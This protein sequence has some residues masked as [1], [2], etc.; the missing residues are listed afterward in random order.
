MHTCMH[1]HMQIKYDFLLNI[2]FNKVHISNKIIYIVHNFRCIYTYML[3]YSQS[4]SSFFAVST[5]DPSAARGWFWVGRS[6]FVVPRRA[7]GCFSSA[8]FLLEFGRA[9]VW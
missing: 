3:L 2:I 4:C 8:E 5:F 7:A 1:I 9:N 6:F